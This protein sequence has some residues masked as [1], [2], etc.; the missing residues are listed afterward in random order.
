[1]VIVRGDGATTSVAVTEAVNA[2]L[3]ES[4]TVKVTLVLPLEV[5]SPD[6]TPLL[7]RLSPAGNAL[8]DQVYGAA[9]PLTWSEPEYVVPTTPAGSE[10]VI[11]SG[12]GVTGGVSGG[13]GVVTG[14]GGV[15]TGGGTGIF[16]ANCIV[17]VCA[18]EPESVTVIANEELPP[19]L[20]APEITPVVED[21]LSPEGNCPPVTLQVY[22]GVPP[23]AINA[24]L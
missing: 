10:G 20:G 16:K 17:A 3:L 12:V 9:P 2:G 22:A 23:L 1:M 5:G 14:G 19:E 13:G 11:C 15:E 24:T 18:G 6:S 21:R 4:A 7:P 8:D